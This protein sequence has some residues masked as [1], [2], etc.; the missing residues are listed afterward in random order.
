MENLRMPT[1]VT[2]SM[3]IYDCRAPETY[4]T[5]L[6]YTYIISYNCVWLV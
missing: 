3:S 5:F 4:K 1:E 6:N 2:N